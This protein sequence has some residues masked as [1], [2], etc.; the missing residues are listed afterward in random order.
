MHFKKQSLLEPLETFWIPYEFTS[1]FKWNVLTKAVAKR[2]VSCNFMPNEMY[3]RKLF[4]MK[5]VLNEMYWRIVAKRNVSRNLMPNQR[6]LF[7]MKC[8]DITC[9]RWNV[10]SINVT[11]NEL[12]WLNFFE[13][14]CID[15]S[16][17]WFKKEIYLKTF[18]QMKS[19]DVTIES[20]IEWE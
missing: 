15:I 20:E 2:N 14:K 4:Q 10:W 1:C 13:M 12:Y 11:S 7:Q 5:L 16:H 17:N 8:I 3:Q 9:F 19:M 6:N 18:L